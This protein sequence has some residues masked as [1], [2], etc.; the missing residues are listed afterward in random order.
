MHTVSNP[1]SLQPVIKNDDDL[2]AQQ[3][4]EYELEDDLEEYENYYSEDHS[5]I[6]EI[7]DEYIYEGYEDDADNNPAVYLTEC[8]DHKIPIECLA[9]N[10]EQHSQ[11]DQ[12]F[13]E[14]ANVFADNISQEGQS[15][16]LGQTT[17]VVHEIKTGDAKPIK[18][19]AYRTVPDEKE[20]LREEITAMLEKGIIRESK[21]PWSS[22]VVIVPKKNGKRRLCVD[23]RK[24]NKET[25]KDVYP[26]PLID[27]IFDSF[28]D[29]KWFTSL[30]LASGYWQVAM[31]ESDKKKTAFITQMGTYEFNVMP[32]GLCNAPATF[33][34]LMDKILQTYI[35][36]FVVVY[37]DDLTIYSDTFENHLKH[38]STIFDTLQQANLKI[39]LNKCQFFLSEIK[40][41]GHTISDEGIMPDEEKVVKVKNFTQ[42]TN[43]R[44]LRG[45]LGLA[46]YY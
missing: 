42:P 3:D 33:Q 38:L 25:E 24:L 6:N 11:I 14:Y 43:L 37:L 13:T 29:A 9:L 16:E 17:E 19:R 10:N 34:R 27:E 8:P 46:S 39:N 15:L 1:F 44:Q 31:K 30:D 23:Y 40:F 20:F 22:P 41:L 32:F 26:L 28:K 12:L 5:V 2:Q 4:L 21:S 18:L 7:L 35:G 45:F 36:K